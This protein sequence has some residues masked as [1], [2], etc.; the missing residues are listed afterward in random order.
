MTTDPPGIRSP[1]ARGHR[2]GQFEVEALLGA[3]G[4]GEVYRARDTRLDRPVAIKL[5]PPAFAADPGRLS[6]FEREA[7]VLASLNHPNIGAVYGL[8]PHNGATA[9]VMEL[10]DGDD[11]AHRIESGLLPIASALAI[12]RQIAA[13][14]EAA[15][16]QGVI[17]RD[18]KP[19]NIKVRPD[20]TVKVLDFGLAKPLAPAGTDVSV[21]TL[22]MLTERVVMG[23]PAYMSPEQARGEAVDYQADIWAF[24]VVLYELLTGAA[25]FAGKTTTDTLARVLER[26]P[27]ETRLP[28]D[29]PVSVRRLIR[30]CLEKDRRRRLHHI[31]DVRIEI[32]DALAPGEQLDRPATAPARRRWPTV[33]VATVLAVLTGIGGWWLASRVA[34][35]AG[36]S[37]MRLSIPSLGAPLAS[38]YGT[39]HLAISKDGSRMAY[40]SRTGLLVRRIGQQQ[41]VAIAAR[42][43]QPFFSPDGQWVAFFS[44]DTGTLMK[45]PA[46][47]GAV[48]LVSPTTDRPGGGTWGEDGTIVFATSEG[49]YR[50]SE[51]GGAATLLARPD[52][53]QHERALAWPQ[54]MPDGRSVLF[55][56]LTEGSIE[57]AQIALL[58]LRTRQRT[59]VLKGG[60]A[61]QY[62]SNGDLVFAS[63]PRLNIVS[64]DPL[65]GRLDGDPVA[66]ADVVLANTPDNGAADFAVSET[67]TLI[68]ASS[69]PNPLAGRTVYWTDRA[70]HEEPLPLPPGQYTYP[71]V[72]SDGTQVA[73]DIPGANRDIWIWNLARKTL[74]RLTDGPNEDNL[75]MWSVDG[76]R[77]FFSSNRTN[78]IDIYSQAADGASPARLEFAAP[79]SQF[80]IGITPDGRHL[81]VQDEFKDLGLLD[82]EHP[83]RLQPLLHSDFD[84][85][86]GV[87]SPDG[88]W[89]A[90]ESNEASDR[91]EVFVRPFPNVTARRERVSIEGGRYPLWGTKRSNELFYVDPNG[92][93]MSASVT[94][95]PTLT[96]GQVTPL[97]TT[98]KPSP[99]ISG[100]PYDISPVDRRFI[101]G[102]P[103]PGIAT[104]PVDIRVVVNWFDELRQRGAGAP[105]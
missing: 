98:E 35:T 47:G 16:A 53:A 48:T 70:G 20:G 21:T 77:L 79:G 104:D 2:I 60:T 61:A 68:F 55:T 30:R 17:H 8:E 74:T 23:T 25:P 49:L 44:A 37:V 63:G 72:S 84:E 43:M 29:T 96:I 81:I 90:Y 52:A 88:H 54:L 11:L 6:R 13:A 56:I 40:A 83:E 73:F 62:T 95:Q 103:A 94:L 41:L 4:M 78:N 31:A 87:V 12:A 5:L 65:T 18:L 59:I 19:A 24:G 34:P 26:D 82:V 58:D 91:Y 7:R 100:R 46:S 57:G 89:I 32:E 80:V 36:V 102:R 3:G 39:R 45:V 14:L 10:V 15:H 33:A 9:L 76:R 27:D 93:M 50:I 86:V 66:A 51:D 69:D 75:P 71:R 22:T 1:V 92:I 28:A 101:I 85:R 99:G 105:R 38:P 67:G 42:A 64:F 97:F